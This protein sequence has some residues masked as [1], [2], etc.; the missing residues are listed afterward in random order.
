MIVHRE[1]LRAHSLTTSAGEFNV[2]GVPDSFHGVRFYIAENRLFT[3]VKSETVKSTAV[4]TT[5]NLGIAPFGT[6][7][8]QVF[9][10]IY[11]PGHTNAHDY[12]LVGY[13]TL[14][15]YAT[16]SGRRELYGVEPWSRG[17][18]DSLDIKQRRDVYTARPYEFSVVRLSKCRT[19]FSNDSGI[20]MCGPRSKDKLIGKYCNGSD[21]EKKLAVMLI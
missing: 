18:P 16:I 21:N 3:T 9:A 19:I 12:P 4:G 20:M 8:P 5:A 13:A 2:P 14:R 10:L 11:G 15:A 7:A 17:S 1:G 6:S